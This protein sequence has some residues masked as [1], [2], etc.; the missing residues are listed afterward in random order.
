MFPFRGAGRWTC[1]SC[2]Y[3]RAV[4]PAI[5]RVARRRRNAHAA[6]N[7]TPVLAAAYRQ[8]RDAP[9]QPKEYLATIPSPVIPFPSAR[10]AT[11]R[12]QAEGGPAK[13]TRTMKAAWLAGVCGIL[14]VSA[15]PSRA[16][17]T[18]AKPNASVT[19][20]GCLYVDRTQF[21]LSD[22]PSGQAPKKRNWKTAFITKTEKDVDLVDALAKARL[23]DHIG[24]LSDRDRRKDQR[25]A[26]RGARGQAR[27]TLLVT[28]RPDTDFCRSPCPPVLERERSS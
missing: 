9:L 11:E 2:E 21:K 6:P 4:V 3:T 16:V 26:T 7:C 5:P 22:L 14:F 13:M 19:L 1:P 28:P 18:Q 15:Q 23:Q 25:H 17:G 27:R 20:T 12:N 24:H 10:G 8:L